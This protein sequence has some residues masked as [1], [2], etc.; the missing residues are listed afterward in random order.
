MKINRGSRIIVLNR[1]GAILENFIKKKNENE[2]T[3]KESK[4]GKIQKPLA[5]SNKSVHNFDKNQDLLKFSSYS[6]LSI[7]LHTSNIITMTSS[8]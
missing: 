2:Q 4:T 6:N 8:N 7:L 1:I 3:E 5:L